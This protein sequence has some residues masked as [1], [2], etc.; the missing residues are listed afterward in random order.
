MKESKLNLTEKWSYIAAV[1]TFFF[2]LACTITIFLV[3][4]HTAASREFYF[5]DNIGYYNI[6]I[7]MLDRFRTISTLDFLRDLYHSFSDEISNLFALPLLPFLSVLGTSRFDFIISLALSYLLPA[8]FLTSWLCSVFVQQKKLII[9]WGTVFTLLL[10]PFCWAAI[11]DGRPDIGGV[12]LL[13]LPVL[14]ATNFIFSKAGVSKFVLIGLCLALLPLFRRSFLVTVA[15]FFIA[16]AITELVVGEKL[17][18]S[19]K[20]SIK[21]LKGPII[22]VIAWG[23]FMLSIGYPFLRRYILND[24]MQHYSS[25]LF[26]EDRG[27]KVVSL[28]TLS[29][30]SVPL[31]LFSVVGL[32]GGIKKTSSDRRTLKLAWLALL[33]LGAYT[34]LL[35]YWADKWSN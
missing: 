10:S 9:F 15:A 7:E 35:F 30:Y 5:W 4:Q 27:W 11:L 28:F 14:V 20:T 22:A 33:F 21:K 13:L 29:F 25:Y 23:L 6:A 24:V 34:C 12:M 2:A 18:F 16:W 19:F 31:L 3:R 8:V 32:I 26:V 17:G 1:N